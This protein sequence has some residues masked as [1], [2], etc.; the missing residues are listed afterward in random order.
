MSK[1]GRSR[2]GGRVP[3]TAES[4]QY[5][6][7]FTMLSVA[8]RHAPYPLLSLMAV[9]IYD[10]VMHTHRLASSCCLIVTWLALC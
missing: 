9:K 5:K 8:T 2:M 1:R 4:S 7:T 6:Y 10:L 3:S